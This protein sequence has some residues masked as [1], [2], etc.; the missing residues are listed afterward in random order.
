MF[1]IG[2]FL[3]ATATVLHYVFFTYMLIVIARALLSWVNPDPYNPI[4]RFLYSATEPVLY[5]IRRALPL[6]AG[7]IDFTPMILIL[8]LVF[9]DQFVVPSLLRIAY[10]LGG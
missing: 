4:V 5:R 8:G 9:L 10:L 6:S 7:S 3:A 1:I 2:Y